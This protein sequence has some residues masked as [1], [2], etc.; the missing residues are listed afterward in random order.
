MFFSQCI[1][2]A[3]II[4]LFYLFYFFINFFLPIHLQYIQKYP[5]VYTLVIKIIIN[6]LQ[7]CTKLYISYRFLNDLQVY[8]YRKT[9]EMVNKKAKE[10]Y[11]QQYARMNENPLKWP[12]SKQ[13]FLLSIPSCRRC[14]AQ[15]SHQRSDMV[16]RGVSVCVL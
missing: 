1:V 15:Y 9:Q 10:S 5:Q 4:I 6:T 14:T 7:L 13:H 3:L 11:G 8:L 12:Q 16:V 2:Y